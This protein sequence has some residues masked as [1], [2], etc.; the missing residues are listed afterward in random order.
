MVVKVVMLIK[1][2]KLAFGQDKMGA[3]ICI[4]LIKI[5]P[6]VVDQENVSRHAQ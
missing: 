1:D 6:I 5:N 3:Q 4:Q 2:W